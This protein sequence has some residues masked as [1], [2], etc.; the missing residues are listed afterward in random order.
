MRCCRSRLRA[1][2][3]WNSRLLLGG[4]AP[5][6]RLRSGGA[7]RRIS[8]HGRGNPIPPV[9]AAWLDVHHSGRIT[10]HSED[11]TRAVFPSDRESEQDEHVGEEEG[12]E[13][14]RH[15]GAGGLEA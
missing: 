6:Y 8:G 11:V 4:R 10:L 9:D 7:T 12:T 3:A 5:V 2:L 13:D 1:P 14:G 15:P